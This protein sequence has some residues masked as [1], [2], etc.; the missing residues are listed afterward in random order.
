MTTIQETRMARAEF[1]KRLNE[2]CD[3][4]GLP[5]KGQGRQL[6]VAKLFGVSQ[7]GARK[8]LEGEAMPETSRMPKFCAIFDCNIDW[9]LVGRGAKRDL[10][11]RPESHPRA[12]DVTLGDRLLQARKS[13]GLTQSQLAEKSGQTQQMISKLESGRSNE[14]AGIVALA[15]ACGVRPEWLFNG[16]GSMPPPLAEPNIDPEALALARAIEALSPETRRHL[17]AL[18]SSLSQPVRNDNGA[19]QFPKLCEEYAP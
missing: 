2:L 4:K 17:S 13:S 9:L 3:E 16:N 6:A 19:T 14:T 15:M 7:K 10:G 18:V 12:S 8:W 1:S 11:L 5:L